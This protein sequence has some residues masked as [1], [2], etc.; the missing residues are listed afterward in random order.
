MATAQEIVFSLEIDNRNSIKNMKELIDRQKEL[1][2]AIALATDKGSEGYEELRQEI[3]A[4]QKEITEFNRDLRNSA[5]I[6]QRVSEGVTKS[7]KQVG[8]VIAGAFA[9]NTLGDFAQEVI[10]LTS[11]IED[12]FARV[13]TVAQLSADDLEKLKDQAIAI[14]KEGGSELEKIP[15]ALFDIVSG[16]GDTELSLKLL[17][18]S[19]KATDAGFGD[20]GTTATAGVNILNA[21]GREAISTNELFD[22]LFATQ[23]EGVVSFDELSKVLPNVIPSAKAVGFSF[24]ETSSAL[25]TL[26]KQGLDA[27]SAGTSLRA[28][29]ST[30]SNK[31]KLDRLNSTLE[32]VGSSVFDADGKLRGLTDIVTDFD[33]VL[34]QATSDEERAAILGDLNLDQNSVKALQGLTSGLEDFTAVSAS[35]GDASSGLGELQ[36][37]LEL[38]ENGTRSLNQ[39]NNSFKA[40]LLELGQK[41]VPGLESA[42]IKLYEILERGVSIL[43]STIEF[44]EENEAAALILKNTLLAL[45][46]VI[47]LNVV[48]RLVD[49]AKKAEILGKAFVLLRN[50]LGS[51]IGLF[52]KFTKIAR[53]NPIGAIITGITLAVTA[54]EYF[55]SETEKASGSVEEFSANSEALKGTVN[56]L[57]EEL[58]KEITNSNKLF[59]V[60][61]SDTASRE[62]KEKVMQQINDQYGDY[63]PSLLTEKQSL[64]DI[65]RAQNAVNAALTRTFTLKI[66][67]ATQ[68]DSLTEKIKTQQ[69][70]FEELQKTAGDRFAA[71]N[72]AEFQQVL[73]GLASSVTDVSSKFESAAT[74]PFLFEDVDLGNERLNEFTKSFR[75]L[76]N[77]KDIELFLSNAVNTTRNFNQSINSTGEIINNLAESTAGLNNQFSETPKIVKKSTDEVDKGAKEIED[78]YKTA[79]DQIKET[80]QVQIKE[81]EA[82]FLQRKQFL[83]ELLDSSNLTE[84][85][86]FNLIKSLSDQEKILKTSVRDATKKS[87]T[88]QLNLAKEFNKDSEL[89][90]AENNLSQQKNE[91]TFVNF[92][93]EQRVKLDSEREKISQ[94]EIERSLIRLQAEAETAE[95]EINLFKEKFKAREDI[96]KESGVS[97]ERIQ[98]EKNKGISA[99]VEKFAIE[100][101]NET[102]RIEQARLQI[103]FNEG[104]QS[105]E[106]KEA[107]EQAKLKATLKRQQAELKL[108]QDLGSA[109]EARI[110]ELKASISGISSQIQESLGDSDVT[111]KDFSN[112]FSDFAG[113]A[114]EFTGKLQ[115]LFNQSTELALQGLDRQSEKAQLKIDGVQEELNNIDER[116]ANANAS[117]RAALIKEKKEIQQRF[118][119]EQEGAE[120][121]EAEKEK[122]RKEAFERNK[123]FAILTAVVNGAVAITKSIA[124]LGPIAGAI[125]AVTT[126]V[127][128]ATQVALIASQKFALG[129]LIESD[130][131]RRYV[132][133][134]Y[135]RGGSIPMSFPAKR[136]GMIKGPSHKRGGVPFSVKG[137]PGFEAQGGEFISSTPTTRMFYP[138]LSAMNTIG[139]RLGN[140]SASIS[141]ISRVPPSRTFELGGQIPNDVFVTR[142]EFQSLLKS[143]EFRDSKLEE[144][145]RETNN[146]LR[147]MKLTLS[148][149]EVQNGLTEL[150]NSENSDDD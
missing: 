74:G 110:I 48:N 148:L 7:F 58:S 46:T 22:V 3:K 31:A 36:K 107:F 138:V 105:V 132:N 47:S 146:L 104:E 113:K 64:E 141:N 140:N 100:S 44:F 112:S 49:V 61:K 55:N 70:A 76:A 121:L 147:K 120:K 95:R 126:G 145:Q 69:T 137:K 139:N 43:N 1:K 119:E 11:T 24:Q 6:A 124:D 91:N 102:E 71:A 118:N 53:A 134:M 94:K 89:L 81:A 19:V 125:A 127:I 75:E 12:G 21:V 32:T 27:T 10:E 51:V 122:I 117:Q 115:T 54:W 133:V 128:T 20:L 56:G 15:D 35:I 142:D 116:I 60:L 150:A 39:A 80:E 77:E 4:N 129:G 99:I 98:E 88:D 9:L 38:S 41:V 136:G 97:E 40:E 42:Q 143:M 106:Q 86:R 28:F 83:T 101:L 52:S 26:T 63:L 87:L 18:T 50:P 90:V 79:L 59:E 78:R 72:F 149:S 45:G 37:Q 130:S 103:E 29:F 30:F 114:T 144:N 57:N 67:E 8:S 65:E 66:Q 5:P 62:E 96:L 17:E 84:Q 34:S 33:T 68:A 73:E 93:I 82:T 108:L 109:D 2:K 111:F 13:N 123:T 14:G 131:D 135:A 85:Q 23:K 25:A 92:V 16:T